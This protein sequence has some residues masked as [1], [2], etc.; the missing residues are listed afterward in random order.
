MFFF[1]LHQELLFAIL[2][3]EKYLRKV[4]FILDFDFK[5]FDLNFLVGFSII[6]FLVLIYFFFRCDVI[7]LLLFL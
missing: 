4:R 7:F 1:I 6:L 2:N 3:H 5:Q